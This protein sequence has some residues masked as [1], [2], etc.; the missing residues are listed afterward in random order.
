MVLIHEARPLSSKVARPLIL[1]KLKVDDTIR[2][3]SKLKINVDDK[4]KAMI[5]MYETAICDEFEISLKAQS[6][7]GIDIEALKKDHPEINFQQYQTE[8]E[9]RVLRV[10]RKEL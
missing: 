9:F 5:G 7:P 8:T 4:L 1:Q 2:E 10:K 3:F 6:R